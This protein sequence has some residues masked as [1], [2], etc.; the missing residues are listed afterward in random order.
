MP[1]GLPDEWGRAA[2]AEARRSLGRRACQ[3]RLPDA[4]AAPPARDRLHRGQRESRRLLRQGAARTSRSTCSRACVSWT[5][6]LAPEPEDRL[7]E[8]H[9]ECSF[10]VLAGAPLP[11]KHTPDGLRARRAL[12]RPCFGQLVDGASAGRR[13]RRRARCVRGALVGRALLPRRPHR[14][15]RRDA[16]R[17]RPADAHRH[18]SQS[19][20]EGPHRLRHHRHLLRALVPHPG[21]EEARAGRPSGGGA[22]HGRGGGPR[23]GSRRCSWRR[24]T[25]RPTARPGRPPRRAAP[26]EEA[27]RPSPAGRSA[28]VTT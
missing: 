13:G 25:R 27:V 22:R 4:A 19:R 24:R 9:P 15:R 20:E 11:S 16:G 14:A 21:P 23:S 28:R 5:S 12:L 6:W 26:R 17:L 1:I 10:Q 3:Q 7:L 8:I 2:D 18:V